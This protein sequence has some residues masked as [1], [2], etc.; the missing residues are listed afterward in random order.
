M[1]IVIFTYSLCAGGAERV[2]VN[3]ANYWAERGWKITIITLASRALDFYSVHPYVQRIVLDMSSESRNVS[4]AAMNNLKRIIVLRRILREIRPNIALGI[5][6]TANVLLCLSA[7]GLR[8]VA[9][10]GSEH[11]YPPM[12]PLTRSWQWLRRWTYPLAD[13]ITMLTREGLDWLEREIPGA[14]GVVIPSPILY[15]LPITEPG[16]VPG[17]WVGP[18]R[19]L[20]LAV[21]RLTEQKRFDWLLQAFAE[22][23]SV[24][25]DWDLVILGEGE[26]RSRLERQVQALELADRVCLPGRAGN[27]SDWYTRADLYVMSSHFEGFPNTLGEAMAH[28]CAA[29]SFDCD[30]GPRDLIR[31]EVDGLLV[32]VGDV[33]CLATALQRLM[34]DDGLRHRMAGCAITVRERFSLKKI[35]GMWEVLFAKVRQ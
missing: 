11:I 8:N 6:P 16:L 4:V 7:I 9:V 13:R 25:P 34:G 32:P 12:S 3:L 14:R 19:K 29:V 20:L 26:L 27:V 15:P 24:N 18:D 17:E 31:H 1:Y 30:T 5:M 22:L 2:T 23:A 33:A 35:A 21:G 10:V 28:G